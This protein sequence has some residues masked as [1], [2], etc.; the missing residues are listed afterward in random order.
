[1]DVLQTITKDFS[2]LQTEFEKSNEDC[3]ISIESQ[4]KRLADENLRTPASDALKKSTI[5][6][7]R[8]K[9]RIKAIRTLKS[10]QLGHSS[11]TSNLEE[12]LPPAG[13]VARV[14]IRTDRARNKT[15]FTILPAFAGLFKGSTIGEPHSFSVNTCNLAKATKLIKPLHLERLPILRDILEASIRAEESSRT[16]NKIPKTIQGSDIKLEKS[17]GS[18]KETSLY[19]NQSRIV[20]ETGS[21]LLE[22]SRSS[23]LPMVSQSNSET[24]QLEKIR[25]Y[26]KTTPFPVLVKNNTKKVEEDEFLRDLENYGLHYDKLQRVN[27]K[28]LPEKGKQNNKLNWGCPEDGCERHFEKL[29]KLK[30]HIFSHRNIRPY[31]CDRPGCLWAFPT[32]FK[33][34]RHQST[35]H[36]DKDKKVK[37]ECKLEQCSEKVKVFSSP[38]NLNQHLKRHARPFKHN[39]PAPGCEVAFQT[40]MELKSHLKSSMHRSLILHNLE[41][42]IEGSVDSGERLIMLPEHI[43]HTCGKRFYNSKDLISHVHQFHGSN[44]EHRMSKS[45]KEARQGYKCTFEGCDKMFGLPSRLAA[46]VRTHTGERPYPCSWPSC[47]WSFRTSSKLK[48]HE[49]SHTNE[50]KHICPICSK[51][52]NRPEHLKAH[53]LAIH[54]PSGVPERFVCPLE[55][56]GKRF[57]A[58]STLYVHMKRH[59]RGEQ[60][61]AFIAPLFR[62]VIESCDQRFGDRNELRNHVSLYHVQELAE[63]AAGF[64]TAGETEEMPQNIGGQTSLAAPSDQEAVAAAAELDFIALLSSVGD[65]HEVV[66]GTNTATEINGEG[67]KEDKNSCDQLLLHTKSNYDGSN[68]VKGNSHEYDGR[69][70]LNK[71]KVVTAEGE[72]ESN[73]GKQVKSTEDQLLSEMIIET[74][75][76]NSN[77]HSKTKDLP[78]HEDILVKRNIDEKLQL[79]FLSNFICKNEKQQKDDSLAVPSVLISPFSND[80]Q[81]DKTQTEL[82]TVDASA[83]TPV[84]LVTDNGINGASNRLL[85]EPQSKL[86]SSISSTPNIIQLNHEIYNSPEENAHVIKSKQLSEIN[87]RSFTGSS[88]TRMLSLDNSIIPNTSFSSLTPNLS[89]DLKVPNAMLSKR[90]RKSGN[91]S[92]LKCNQPNSISKSLLR[93][94]SIPPELMNGVNP[95]KR[96]KL[97]PL[98]PAAES[99]FSNNAMAVSGRKRPSILRRPKS[100]AN[101]SNLHSPSPNKAC[102]NKPEFHSTEVQFLTASA[103][104]ETNRSPKKQKLLNTTLKHLSSYEIFENDNMSAL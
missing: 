96:S 58:R 42:D 61:G 10:N 36:A 41:S 51:A 2:H 55:E 30:I 71:E 59:T 6:D 11:F 83:I 89:H 80:V 13:T 91:V 87:I 17:D 32:A 99:S 12:H 20:S 84:K 26:S 33:L 72:N 24:I 100:P 37:Y 86:L 15:I 85:D 47:G 94:H 49:R 82:I 23:N 101:I 64:S 70:N 18:L 19:I 56:C 68:D 31:N 21:L 3:R 5:T 9:L 92:I 38:Y 35:A 53:I 74:L 8:K 25:E 34:K 46:H 4:G 102:L 79:P 81:H 54:N 60:P 88:M 97:I 98:S 69:D 48:R 45:D 22:K 44:D 14:E 16:A 78:N 52:Y 90:K 57:S 62:C 75:T 77:Q 103:T 104:K 39:C 66:I 7:G 43:C 27:V 40:M 63:S 28:P 29:S 65:E 50:R 95:N 1:M 67:N 93:T 76:S 73:T